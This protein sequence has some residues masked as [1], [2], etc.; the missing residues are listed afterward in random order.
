MVLKGPFVKF[1]VRL[2]NLYLFAFSNEPKRYDFLFRPS[3]ILHI[4]IKVVFCSQKSLGT[5]YYLQVSLFGIH[6][7]ALNFQLISF[8]NS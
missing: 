1:A 7:V 4:L 5:M 6:K 8:E 2:S 3:A